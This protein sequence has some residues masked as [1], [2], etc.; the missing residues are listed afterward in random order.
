MKIITKNQKSAGVFYTYRTEGMY[1]LSSDMGLTC[2]NNAAGL[3][4]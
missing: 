3:V 2:M 4:V 1:L